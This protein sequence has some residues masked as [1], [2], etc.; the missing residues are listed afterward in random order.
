MAGWEEEPKKE[1]GHLFSSS[2]GYGESVGEEKDV[3]EADEVEFA[4]S[5]APDEVTSCTG[6]N[7]LS[8]FDNCSFGDS[9]IRA[10]SAKTV[11]RLEAFLCR[12]PGDIRLALV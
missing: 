10:G 6:R 11:L 7:R 4:V 1:R 9:F 2:V 8:E 3:D 5:S 12:R